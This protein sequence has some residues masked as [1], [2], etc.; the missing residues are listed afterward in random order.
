MC[1]FVELIA[2]GLV[3]LR[4]L[5][6]VDVAPEAG[7]AVD[8]AVAVGVDEVEA[9]GAV[10]DQRGLI[11]PLAHGGEGVP[12]MLVVKLGEAFGVTHSPQDNYAWGGVHVGGNTW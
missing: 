1:D 12:D 4:D 2:D 11:A 7:D 5:V 10:D 3:D 8:V 6:A 9:F